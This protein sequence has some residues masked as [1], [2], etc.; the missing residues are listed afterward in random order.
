MM[1]RLVPSL[2][3]LGRLVVAS[4]GAAP[5]LRAGRAGTYAPAVWYRFENASDFGADSSQFGRTFGTGAK[6]DKM[7][8]PTHEIKGG[9]VGG[10][11]SFGSDAGGPAPFTKSHAWGAEVKGGLPSAP[12]ITIEFLLRPNA[13]FMR[14]G[15]SEPLPG[16]TFGVQGITWRVL[17]RTS[18]PQETRELF[19]SLGG[20]GVLAADYLWGAPGK[21]DGWHHIAASMDAKSG[22]LVFWIDGE[23]QPSMQTTLIAASQVA[24]FTVFDIDKREVVALYACLDE[25]AVYQQAL[26]PSLIYQHFQDAL[27]HHRPYSAADLGTPAPPP[28]VYPTANTSEYYDL[29]EYPPGTQ[30][31]SPAGT[32][33]TASVEATCVQ[34]LHSVPP[35]RFNKSSIA[36]YFT[37]FNFNWMDPHYMAGASDVDPEIRLNNTNMTVAL[38]RVMAEKFRYGLLKQGLRLGTADKPWVPNAADNATFALANSHPEWP[39]N[40]ICPFGGIFRNETKPDGC[41][42]QNAKGQFIQV[43]GAVVAPGGRKSIRPMSKTMAEAEGCPDSIWA[44]E[45]ERIRDFG[46]KPLAQYLTRPLNVINLDGEVFVDVDHP[47]EDYKFIHDPKVVADFNASGSP[48]WLTYWSTWRVRLTKAATDPYMLDSGLRAGV[49]KGAYLTMYQVQGTDNYFGNWTQ[50]REIGSPMPAG[51]NRSATMR[52][53]TTD[54]Y[55][56]DPSMWWQCGGSNHAICWVDMSRQSELEQGDRLFSPFMAAGWSGKAEHN[57]RPA[58]WLGLLKLVAA[59]GAEWFYAGFFNVHEDFHG[60]MPGS[61]QWCWQGM[62]PAYAQATFTQVAPFVYDGALVLADEN[63]TLAMKTDGKGYTYSP[64]LWAGQPN[65]MAIARRFDDVFLLTLAAQRNSNAALNLLNKNASATIRVP[66]L[67]VGG[68]DAV[69]SVTARLQG[70]VYLFRDDTEGSPVMYQVDSWHKASHPMYWPHDTASAGE[71]TTVEAE[72]F[73]GHLS[74]RGASVM[75]TLQA[76]GSNEGD[77]RGFRTYVDL[78]A[79]ARLGVAL[80]YPLAEHGIAVGGG[81]GCRVRLLMRTGGRVDPCL[82]NGVPLVP[83]VEEGGGGSSGKD[84][85]EHEGWAW[86]VAE[87]V[88]VG[89]SVVLTTAGGEGGGGGWV[90]Q[91]EVVEALPGRPLDASSTRADSGVALNPSAATTRPLKSDDA[92]S[93]PAARQQNATLKYMSVCGYNSTEEEGWLN[94]GLVDLLDAYQTSKQLRGY[95]AA[96]IP[97]LLPMPQL[98]VFRRYQR[99][100]GGKALVASGLVDG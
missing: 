90:D 15:S 50:T 23:S 88:V 25:V 71:A 58:Q 96:H 57:T 51:S 13:G 93:D 94:L 66:G 10:F 33:N 56:T 100:G 65:I 29:K 26:P 31:P 21:Y 6:Q 44:E 36:E 48:N 81:G 68:V 78:G 97:A 22:K 87:G 91:L 24:A 19:M 55:M 54:M 83:E 64:L 49:L 45:G 20:A 43:T 62:M 61:S 42:L 98:G 86:H 99:W 14:G 74:H 53:S 73:S 3:L 32:N 28:S 27:V 18:A 85:D 67:T 5:P 41:Y 76:R 1:A 16:V 60:R 89:S 7:F 80:E 75:R 38:Q 82:A 52:F 2:L 72:L 17:T 11:L 37:P 59:W 12:G 77:Y 84:G 69:L 95:A 79:A 92:P 70:S 8:W 63:T 4:D 47:A 40:T 34:Q 46:F 39:F 9:P 35:P 30:L